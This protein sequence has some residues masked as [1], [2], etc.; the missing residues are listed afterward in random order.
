MW[1]V[2]EKNYKVSIIVPVY[3]VAPFLEKCV[4]SI[5]SQTWDFIVIILV[6]DGSTDKSGLICDQ[7]KQ[8]DNRIKVLHK[9]NDGVSAAQNSGM[10]MANGGFICFVDGDDYVMPD[11]IEYMLEQ[12]VKNKADI[13]LITRM[14]GNFEEKQV[15]S[16]M[17]KIWNG[18][19]AVE[20][21]LCYQVPIGCYCKLFRMEFLDQIK[22]IPEIFIGE[23]FISMWR[24]FKKW[25]ELLQEK[26]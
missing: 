25:K 18:E 3:N 20:A 2:I 16:D 10:E 9:R 1:G 12:I 24:L 6:D 8:K 26:E 13:A 7:M 4:E 11:Y 5:L 21:I 17:T 19:D 22:F 23:G 14:F 15:E